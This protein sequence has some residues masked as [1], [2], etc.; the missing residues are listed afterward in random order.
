MN[1]KMNPVAKTSTSSEEFMDTSDET[2]NNM[3]NIRYFA[4][5]ATSCRASGC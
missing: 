4:G 5:G 3:N 2:E 1:H